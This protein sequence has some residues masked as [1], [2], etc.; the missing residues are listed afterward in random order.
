MEGDGQCTITSP[1]LADGKIF[2]LENNGNNLVMVRADPSK[3]EALGKAN[4]RA[5]WCPTPAISTDGRALIRLQDQVKC[6]DL[7][8]PASGGPPAAGLR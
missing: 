2:I 6:V 1:V 5:L 4:V 3:H 7:T 8:A